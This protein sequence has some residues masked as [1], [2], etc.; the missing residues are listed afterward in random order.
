MDKAEINRVV[1]RHKAEQE[2]LDQRLEAL[3]S[4]KLQV[5]RTEDGDVQDETHVHI[6]EL[7]RLR[8][9]LAENVARY[10]ALLGA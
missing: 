5:A 8:Q 9:W 2:A 7:E 10:E 6:S 3:R 4:G 1:E